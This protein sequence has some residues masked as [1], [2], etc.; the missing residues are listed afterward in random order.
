VQGPDDDELRRVRLWLLVTI[1][2]ASGCSGSCSNGQPG[3]AAAAT[4]QVVGGLSHSCALERDGHVRCWGLASSITGAGDQV[5]PPTLIPELHDVRALAAGADGTCALGADGQVRCFGARSFTVVKSDGEP[6]TG[7]TRVALGLTSGCVL[8]AQG[9]S[10]WGQNDLGQLGRP[11]EVTHSD[12]ALL[13]APGPR[14]FLAVGQTVFTHDGATS[15]CA[16]GHNGTHEITSDD[17]TRVY[18]AAECGTLPDVVQLVAGADHA[19]V[20]HAAGTFACWGERYY[21]QLG[22]GGGVDDTADVVPYGAQT[23]LAAPVRELVAG[24]SHTCAL[25]DDGAVTCFGL[26]SKGQ[27]GPGATTAAEEVRVPAPV[28]GFS[29]RVMALG[30]GPTAQHTCAIVADGEVQCWG[31]DSDGQLGDGVTTRDPNRFS[32]G[33]VTVRRP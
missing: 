7:A 6:L 15:I 21:G 9:T 18:T 32:H 31:S 8:H 20:R 29:G 28:T 17:T 14:R 33:P 24:A 5:L 27:V 16:W 3:T 11:L 1:A 30:A 22:T 10:C 4:I 19:C 25:L 23:S 13:A 26:N 12:R 2:V